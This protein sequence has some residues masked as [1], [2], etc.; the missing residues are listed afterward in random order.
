MASLHLSSA[1]ILF[2]ALWSYRQDAAC[3]ATGTP[4][5][6]L[7]SSNPWMSSGLVKDLSL[8]NTVV[9][10]LKVDY[11]NK[12]TVVINGSLMPSQTSRAPVSVALDGTSRCVPPFALI[13]VDPDA[14]S[15]NA[16]KQRSWMHWMVNNAN[17]ATELHKGEQLMPYAGPTPPPGTG[18]HRY[19][20]LTYCQGGKTVNGA[21]LKPAQRNKF[22]VD[23]FEKKLGGVVPFGGIFFYAE[24]A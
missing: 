5:G 21:N 14:P 13:M 6:Q 15:R 12:A 16:A 2:L 24:S 23:D 7:R 9:G 8:G 11:G 20:F 18:Q 10:L 22:D 3:G 4:S 17:S 19:V 1:S